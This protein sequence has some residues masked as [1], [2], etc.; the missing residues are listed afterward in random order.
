MVSKDA[1]FKKNWL[2]QAVSE[3]VVE[4]NQITITM[5]DEG[6]NGKLVNTTL[7]PQSVNIATVGG[8]NQYISDGQEWTVDNSDLTSDAYICGFRCEVSPKIATTEDIFL[9]AMYVTDADDNT[10]DLPMISEETDQFIG[11]TTLDRMVMFSK[12]GEKVNSAFTITVRDNG[13]ENVICL[14]TDVDAGKWAVS[15][16]G[17]T[18]IVESAE[19]EGCLVF[20]AQPGTYTITPVDET[21]SV[22]E[23]VWEET[24]KEKIGDFTMKVD[25][26]YA[27]V[28]NRNRIVDGKPYIAIADFLERYIG[29]TTQTE[30]RTLK[31]TLKDGRIFIFNAG[32]KEYTMGS[33]TSSTP[34]MLECE[35]FLD[36]NGVFYMNCNGV[37]TRFGFNTAYSSKTKVMK[38]T[39]Y[40][41]EEME[42]VDPSKVLW[43]VAITASSRDGNN[44]PENTIDR[45]LSTRWSSITADGEW[46]LRSMLPSS[47]SGSL[48]KDLQ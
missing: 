48:A 47:W 15:G 5:T 3:P 19:T 44:V 9:N 11:V 21:S 17:N 32:S 10:V 25:A 4:G 45:Q 27:Y 30:G 8:I 6:C 36:A 39:M 12:N 14:M 20:T 46:Y 2:L 24:E 33:G 38:I 34:G 1:S 23:V 41:E 13:Y 31:V 28:K 18:I 40:S 29:A 37:S 26:T 43:P 35:P 16:N 22:T 42:G 7:Y